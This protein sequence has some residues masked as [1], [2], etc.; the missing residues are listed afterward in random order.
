MPLS[1]LQEEKHEIFVSCFASCCIIAFI[2]FPST[3]QQSM[4]RGSPY[5][6]CS[7]WGTSFWRVQGFTH[8]QGL[9][10]YSW[11]V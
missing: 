8:P 11:C 6:T 1:R 2:A 5:R 10:L 9:L 7:K 4:L 3:P